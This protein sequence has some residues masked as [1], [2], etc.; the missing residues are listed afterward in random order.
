[1]AVVSWTIC[2]HDFNIFAHSVPK[3]GFFHS[4]ELISAQWKIS[5]LTAPGKHA[6]DAA[7]GFDQII[8]FS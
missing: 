7:G 3:R 1:M 2:P 5:R 6:P 4:V 8:K